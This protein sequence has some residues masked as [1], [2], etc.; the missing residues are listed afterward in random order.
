MRRKG[1]RCH[2]PGKRCVFP[3]NS[4]NVIGSGILRAAGPGRSGAMRLVRVFSPSFVNNRAKGVVIG[5]CVVP[6][7]ASKRLSVVPLCSGGLRR[8]RVLSL[9]EG[10]FGL[11]RGRFKCRLGLHRQLAR[12]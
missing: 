7:V 2:A 4:K 1:V 3:R 9:V 10:T 12:V 11:S 8:G 6:V 5:G